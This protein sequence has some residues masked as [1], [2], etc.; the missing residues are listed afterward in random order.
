MI[1]LMTYNFYGP[2]TGYTGQ[3]SPLYK[4]SIESPYEKRHL[5]L[6]SSVT[7]WIKEGAPKEKI[8]AGIPFYGRQYILTDPEKNVLHSPI[9]GAAI[10]PTPTYRVV[11]FF[12]FVD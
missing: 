9:S 4:S 2:W 6:N 11:F 10:P 7:N 3:N 1:N 12:S 8:N 5:N